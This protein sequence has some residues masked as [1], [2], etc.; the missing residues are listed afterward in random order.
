MLAV[1]DLLA[2]EV[3]AG[4]AVVL[5]P[6]SYLAF[7]VVPL[8]VVMAKLFGLYDADHKAIRHLTE[9]ELPTIAGLAA[10]GTI[11][12]IMLAQGAS[13]QTVGAINA[14]A[15]WAVA[16]ATTAAFRGAA[17]YLWRKTTPPEST[18]VVGAPELVSAFKRK[19]WLLRG[20]HLSLVDVDPAPGTAVPAEADLDRIDRLVLASPTLDPE[21]LNSL[22]AQCREARTK[23]SVACA[24]TG[25][26]RPANRLSQVGEIPVLEYNTWN[27]PR[28]T[29][30]LKRS[31]DVLV[32]AAALILLSPLLLGIAVAIKLESRG[33]ILFRQRR[34]GLNG[35]VFNMLKFRSMVPD[36]ERRLGE[37]DGLDEERVAMFKPV[38]D[39]RVTSVGRVLRRYS[40]DELPQLFNVLKGEMSIVG[41]RPEKS[42]VVDR[43]RDEFSPRLA[44]RPGITGPM[45]VLGRGHLT[46]DE[47]AALEIEYVEQLSFARDLHLLVMTAPAAVRGTGAF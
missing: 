30:L 24:L 41:P 45:Q 6:D 26:A 16:T 31:F 27:V 8:W 37:V 17:R 22:T 11:F 20:M 46:F 43:H 7:L 38:E 39:P 10:L 36:A 2:A 25:S 40:L 13:G 42:A 33:P 18:A 14:L 5:V 15:L 3:T 34:V 9:D 12:V 32:S 4:L 44:V 35:R 21:L 29:M 47:R 19:T 23:L 28:T 1:A